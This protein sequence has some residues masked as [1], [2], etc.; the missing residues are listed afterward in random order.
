MMSDLHNRRALLRAAA[1]AS[2]AWATRDLLDIEEALAWASLQVTKPQLPKFSIL[3]PDQAEVIAVMTSRILPSVDGRPG[4]REA[5]AVYFIDRSLATFNKSQRQLYSD[6]VMDLNTR[7][8]RAWSESPGFVSL[9]AMQQ[10]TLL[11]TIENTP[12]FQAVRFDTI[13]GT[14]A[15]PAWGGNRDYAGWHLLNFTHRPF[16]EPPFG[17]YD[18]EVNRRK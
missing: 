1:A 10:D 14:F 11:R 8:T 12:F 3:T 13:V 15:L 5:G 16:F 7:A 9:T 4:A 6:G 17:F 18:A 2:A